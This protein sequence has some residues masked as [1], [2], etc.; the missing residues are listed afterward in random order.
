MATRTTG[1]L[2]EY[3]Y[4]PFDNETCTSTTDIDSIVDNV[5]TKPKFEISNPLVVILGISR[6]KKGGANNLAIYR[7]LNKTKKR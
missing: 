3:K 5:A 4:Q 7:L 6:Y 2:T 1:E